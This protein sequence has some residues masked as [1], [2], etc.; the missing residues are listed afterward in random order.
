MKHLNAICPC[1]RKKT[2]EGIEGISL[3]AQAYSPQL[4]SVECSSAQTV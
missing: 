4:N 1:L 2:Q 3:L